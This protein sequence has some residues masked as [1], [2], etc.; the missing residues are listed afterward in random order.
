MAGDTR[1]LTIKWLGDTSSVEKSAKSASGALGKVGTIAAGAFTGTAML[2]GA[3][4]LVGFLGDSTKAAIEDEA[5]QRTLAKTLENTAHA[6]HG[7]VDAVE[8][9]ISRTQAATGVTDDE[10]RPAFANLVRGTH[11]VN[12]AQGLMQTALDVSAG[13]G[14]DLGTVTM[15][16]SKALNGNVG[17]LARLGIKVKQTVPD[18]KALAAAQRN[19]MHAQAAYNEAVKKYGPN[20]SQAA[21][22]MS[23]LADSNA[24]LKDAQ[25]KVKKTTLDATTLMRE[26]NKTYGGQAAAAA[27]TSAGKMKRL[28][29]Q[30]HEMQEE[31]GFKVLPVLTIVADFLLNQLPGAI[32]KVVQWFQTNWPKIY[33][34]ISPLVSFVK[35]AVSNITDLVKALILVFQGLIDF[36]TGVFSGDWGKAWRGIQKMFHGIV[37]AIAA[38]YKEF[39]NELQHITFTALKLLFQLWLKS[40]QLTF[41]L[42][43]QLLH[44]LVSG[45]W[46]LISQLPGLAV[47]GLEWLAQVYLDGWMNVLDITKRVVQWMLD[48]FWRGLAALPGL[49]IRGI[50]WLATTYYNALR[51]LPNLMGRIV[52]DI[53]G[54]FSHLAGWLWSL[55]NSGIDSLVRLFSYAGSR[56]GSALWDATINGLRGIGDAVWS[57]V[58]GGANA[59]IDAWN[60]IDFGIHIHA[61][62]WIPFVGGKGWDIDDIIPDIPRLATGGIT[63]GAG[64][65]YLHPNEL[66]Q[67]LPRNGA[68]GASVYYITVNVPPT[69]DQAKVGQ[70]TVAAIK[71]YELRNGTSWRH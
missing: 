26:L 51:A 71:A 8:K 47:K 4:Q 15:A 43:M 61:P 7:Q 35:S 25:T 12:K 30:W 45:F 37:G 40:W 44:S 22:A 5:S 27:N 20:S 24:K 33:Q 31:I 32:D 55:F 66:V 60:R 50:S 18:T 42:T 56:M 14:K 6:T 70:A 9:Y 68:L 21:T 10:L 49:A 46:Q 1:T 63:K 53:A 57:I 16:M 28:Q 52:N 41:Q 64:I 54:V 19:V 29:A 62:D 17:A 67:P 23:K 38:I 39:W 36:I 58:K 65:A 34:A 13:S 11:D 59:L 2:Q 48:A 69:A 3:E